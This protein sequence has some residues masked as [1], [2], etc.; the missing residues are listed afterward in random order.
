MRVDLKQQPVASVSAHIFFAAVNLPLEMGLSA[1][2][3]MLLNSPAEG[4]ASD[5]P[6]TAMAVISLLQLL[7][8]ERI[9]ISKK[10]VLWWQTDL[11]AL[12][13]FVLRHFPSFFHHLSGNDQFLIAPSSLYQGEY[14]VCRLHTSHS[15]KTMT[16]PYIKAV[17][18]PVVAYSVMD[19]RLTRAYFTLHFQVTVHH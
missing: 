3:W 9:K 14:M 8:E 16:F 5:S 7:K 6:W 13:S 4:R 19:T 17:K 10:H 11:Y 2:A 18:G 1:S 12:A 15:D